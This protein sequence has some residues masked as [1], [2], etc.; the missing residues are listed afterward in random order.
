MELPLNMPTVRRAIDPSEFVAPE[1]LIRFRVFGE[2]QPAPK[3]DSAVIERAGRKARLIPVSHDY[4]TKTVN[5]KT[6]KHDH[7]YKRAWYEL[8]QRWAFG[9]MVGTGMP[10]FPKGVPLACGALVFV[11]R[12]KGNKT[13]YPAQAPDQDNFSYYIRNALKRTPAKKRYGLMVPGPYPE[14]ICYWDDDQIISTAYP[15]KKLWAD[16]RH[17]PGALVTIYR[18]DKYPDHIGIIDGIDCIGGE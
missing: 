5:G 15:D 6:V 14:G 16:E 17:P 9:F 12:P 1:D 2:P 13:G 11:T 10:P 3:K 18:Y 7:G 8:V 4:R